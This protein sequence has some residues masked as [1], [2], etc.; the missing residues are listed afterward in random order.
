VIAVVALLSVIQR[1]I[2]ASFGADRRLTVT[3]VAPFDFALSAAAVERV[4]AFIV[5]TARLRLHPDES[6]VPAHRLALG[7]LTL[8]TCPAAFHP[9][10]R[11]A[12]IPV[13]IVRVIAPLSVVEHA[14]SAW[15][16]GRFRGSR[17]RGVGS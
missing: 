13:S 8:I 5:T 2:P 11:A 6:T 4:G 17:D 10:R 15:V 3:G 14:V 7:R 16:G 1:A 12:A 9:A